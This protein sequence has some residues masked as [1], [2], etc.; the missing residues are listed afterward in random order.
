M[1]TADEL[2]A[3]PVNLLSHLNKLSPSSAIRDEKLRAE[4]AEELAALKVRIKS[5]G[6]GLV[7]ELGVVRDLPLTV[8]QR[9]L[10]PVSEKLYAALLQEGVFP[11]VT[12]DRYMADELAALAER[13]MA[14]QVVGIVE[15]E[16]PLP[17]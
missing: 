5:H 14:G 10:S 16:L 17:W 3:S 4:R 12:R 8:E 1:I 6:E 13:V 7:F 9:R 15:Q 11:T 2:L